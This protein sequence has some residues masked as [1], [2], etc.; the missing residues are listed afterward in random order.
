MRR[1]FF[2]VSAL[3][4]AAW[5]LSPPVFGGEVAANRSISNPN[6]AVGEDIAVTL[7]AQRVSAPVT[8][9][10]TVPAPFD[11]ADAGGGSVAGKTI[12]FEVPA[13]PGGDPPRLVLAERGGTSTRPLPVIVEGGLADGALAMVDRAHVYAQVAGTIVDG[14][15][16]VQVSNDDK[17]TADY[18][19]TVEV[20]RDTTLYLIVD[21]RIGD[22]SNADPPNLL[23]AMTWV[24]DMGFEDT[25]V[26]IAI[27]EGN[28]GSI[29]NYYRIYALPI[30]A[31]ELVVLGTQ[32]D[33]RGRNMYGVAIGRGAPLARFSYVIR[34]AS[35][36]PG[37]VEI[38]GVA[39]AQG[40]AETPIG[41]ESRLLCLVDCGLQVSGG[42]SSVLVLGPI[43]LGEPNSNGSCDDQGRFP[44]T[45]YLVDADGKNGEK[46]LLVEEGDDVIPDFGGN[47]GGAGVAP[48]PNASLNPEPGFLT[49]WRAAA[50][51]QGRVNFNLPENIGD[52]LDDYV[53]YGLVYLENTTGDCL[54]AVIEVGSDDAVKL[55]VNGR[56][57]HANSVCRGLPAY[58]AGDMVPVVLLPGKN[59]VLAAVAEYT[60]GTD[61]RLVVRD[62]N[63]Q[64]LVDG[65]VRAG[66]FPPPSFPPVTDVEVTR[67]FDAPAFTAPVANVVTVTL[68]ATNVAGPTT[69]VDTFPAEAE[70]V[71]A[72]GGTVDGNRISF[73]VTADGDSV[74][75]LRLAGAPSACPFRSAAFGGVVQPRGACASFVGGASTVRCSTVCSATPESEGAELQA[76]F[77]FGTH[78]VAGLFPDADGAW[79][80][81]PNAPGSYYLAVYQTAD[82]LSVAYPNLDVEL[83][84]GVFY[85]DEERTWGYEI[86]YRDAS[87]LLVSDPALPAPAHTARAGWEIYGPF[88]DTANGRDE[89]GDECAEELYDSFIGAKNWLNQDGCNSTT[90]GNPDDPCTAA[91]LEP[92]G[93][94]FRVDVP[95]GTYRFVLAA[96]SADNTHAHRIL[97]EDGGA[98]PPSGIGKHAVLVSNFDQAQYAIGETDG[99]PGDGVYAAVGFGDKLPPAGDG[100][101]PDP[102]FV[103]MDEAGLATNGCPSSPALEVTQ[104]YIRFHCLQANSN[105]GPGGA[106]DPNGGDL[107]LLELWRVGGAAAPV[108]RRG[109]GNADGTLNITDGVFVLNYLFLGGPEPPCLDAADANGD[110]GLNITDGIYVLNYL[111][112]GGPAPP[113]PGPDSCGPAPAGKPSLGCASYKC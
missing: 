108:F 83:A 78:D 36:E 63:L 4:L 14:C 50:D 44:A 89:F 112:L 18:S 69:I 56:G 72:G 88:D 87:G 60:G 61:L 19:L 1:A 86:L 28:N 62:A 70:V 107:V 34:A 73:E 67:S 17:T 40:G 29:E 16:Y 109:D 81:V 10:D 15:T 49:V 7:T 11:I 55:I 9:R 21:Y 66:C 91:G 47:A 2:V 22:N 26:S 85:P 110:G 33:G 20:D 103:Y 98:G 5:A 6:Y 77:A 106:R 75:K 35:C 3:S 31:G 65:S 54:Q 13:D 52:P 39:V 8:L 97:A 43:A 100:G 92:D 24:L 111:F 30:V 93:I 45:D 32:N 71:D 68:S 90:V 82:V 51:A 102:E 84:P 64:P 23:G 99:D 80:E 12:S 53:V 57:V 38:S 58:G 25:G 76:A 104:G 96:G 48:A 74:Y 42:V 94:I 46:D 37:A 105:N 59:V 95:N 41:G 101:A 79:C 27:D 113:A